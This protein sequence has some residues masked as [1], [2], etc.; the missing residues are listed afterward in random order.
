MP[1]QAITRATHILQAVGK[2]PETPTP[3]KTIAAQTGLNPATCA[4]ILQTLVREG[5]IEQ[6]ERRQGYTLGPMLYALAGQGSYRRDLVETAKPHMLR[7]AAN[8]GTTVLLAVLHENRRYSIC[9]AD[10]ADTET[11]H[12]DV[13]AV[14]SPYRSLTGRILLAH[15][16]GDTH[17]WVAK[18]GLPGDLWPEVRDADSL[19][20]QL[21]R[22][23]HQSFCVTEETPTHLS[24]LATPIFRGRTVV[25][26]L[27]LYLPTYKYTGERRESI[28]NDFP[29]T[30]NAISGDL[31]MRDMT[32]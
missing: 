1:V 11:F 28:E 23:K 5:M 21:A 13:W 4:R 32:R 30:G 16:I 15:T 25:A 9:R 26:A 19:A 29:R 18:N 3:L 8:T 17:E 22:L 31:S 10:G 6:A 2:M 27:G 7:L 14:E 12:P 20:H 24:A